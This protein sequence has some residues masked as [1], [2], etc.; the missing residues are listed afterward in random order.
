MVPDWGRII[1]ELEGAGVTREV[2]SSAMGT[3]VSNHMIRFYRDGCQPVWFRGHGLIT[4]WCSQFGRTLDD[5]PM[6]ELRRGY[7]AQGSYTSGPRVQALP[8]W[9][10]TAPVAVAPVK[11]NAGRPRKVAVCE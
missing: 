7:R 6:T 10:P 3:P 2:I 4:L 9:P 5:A 1:D 8:N 11:R